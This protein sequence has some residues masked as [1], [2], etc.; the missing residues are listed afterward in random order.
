[1]ATREQKTTGLA[2]EIGK[3]DSFSNLQQETFLNLLRTHAKL[4]SQFKQQIFRPMGISHEKYNVL[5]ILAGEARPMQI[6]EIAER[7]VTPS[8][9][10]SRLIE[11]LVDSGLVSREKCREDGRVVWI[12]LTRQGRNLLKKIAKPLMDLHA[13]QFAGLSEK[14]LGQLNQ[15]LFK[16]RQDAE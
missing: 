11:R 7:M 12:D 5:R 13:S 1:M 2:G 9:D 8:T 3:R 16:A 15:L 10:I 14:E 4:S 6:Y